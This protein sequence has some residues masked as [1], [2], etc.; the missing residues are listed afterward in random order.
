MQTKKI[1]NSSQVKEIG[2]DAEKKIFA[3]TFLN[4]STYHYENVEPELWTEAQSAESIGKFVN[5]KIKP[6]SYKKVA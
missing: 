6:H 5:Q 3:V 1:E 4:N 2:Y